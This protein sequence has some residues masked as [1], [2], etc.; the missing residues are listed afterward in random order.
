MKT[1]N[2]FLAVIISISI[3]V[4]VGLSGCSSS[5]TAQSDEQQIL[6]SWADDSPTKQ[7]IEEY[8]KDVTTEG[9]EHFIPKQDRIA[10]FD[11]D[12]TLMAEWPITIVLGSAIYRIQTDLSNDVELN[13]M[14]NDFMQNIHSLPKSEYPSNYYTIENEITTKAFK[15]MTSEEVINEVKEFMKT[16]HPD[17]TNLTYSQSFY[18]PMVE[19]VDYLEQNGFSVFIVSGTEEDILKGATC[20]ILDL[21]NVELIGSKTNLNISG[22]GL[23]DNGYV[24]Q[25]ND[26]LVHDEGFY[27]KNIQNQKV[28]N[29]ASEIGKIPVLAFGNSPDDFSMLNYTMSNSQYEHRAFLLNHDDDQ[30]E[31]IYNSPEEQAECQ[32]AAE[33]Y[34]WQYVSIKDEFSQVFLSPDAQKIGNFSSSS[35]TSELSDAA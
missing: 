12:G 34:G 7:A 24:F 5:Q 26:K 17:F 25:P 29:I 18:K 21:P 16:D 15:G 14:L 20:D 4:G 11:L 23:D 19:L 28:Y 1:G 31:Y 2:R 8:V 27:E 30:R 13:N 33:Q 3:V 32:Q 6:A 10:T 9:S 22:A 35:S